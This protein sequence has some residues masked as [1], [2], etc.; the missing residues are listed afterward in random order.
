MGL[1]TQRIRGGG[2]VPSDRAPDLDAHQVFSNYEPSLEA[3]THCFSNSFGVV[4]V[5]NHAQLRLCSSKY[6]CRIFRSS[7]RAIGRGS[8]VSGFRTPRDMHK[9]IGTFRVVNQV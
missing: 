4:I 3:S 9:T 6:A 5:V 2:G 8:V 7:D 1:A